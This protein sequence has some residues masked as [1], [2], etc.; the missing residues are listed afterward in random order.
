MAE[1]KRIASEETLVRVATALESMAN[2]QNVNLIP[3]TWNEVQNIVRNGLATKAFAI[4]DQ[5]EIEK[6]STA[7]AK[8]GEGSTGITAVTVDMQTIVSALSSAG[9]SIAGTFELIY[10]GINWTNEAG[11]TVDI[12]KW[13]VT[14]TGTAKENDTI[15]VTV[16]ATNL[17]FDVIGI[18]V[19]T[20]S[21][22]QFTHS[23]TL[24]L[25]DCY[26]ALQF[27]GTE[28]L[29]YCEEELPA[30]TYNFTLLAG[31]ETTYGGG[32]TYSFTL[33]KAVPAG[34]QIMFPWG[35]QKQAAD[36]KI[37]TYASRIST[38][39]LEEVSVTQEEAGTPLT[40]IGE[41]NHS[42]R[43]RYGSNNWEQ[44]AIRQWLNSDKT[45]G[46]VWAP[47]TKFDRP[48]TWATTTDGFLYGIDKSFLDVIGEVKKVTL[49]NTV[50]DNTEA[51][52]VELDEKFFLLANDELY[53]SKEGGV[54]QGTA[55]PYY[56]NYSD[57]SAPGNAADSNRIKYRNGT[58]SY[59]WM[60]SPIPWNAS[61]VRNVNPTG[62][63]D[64]SGAYNSLGIAP[65]CCIV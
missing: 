2:I 28:A 46:N 33:T 37:S 49:L 23:L 15:V 25:H 32:L 56:K 62:T 13:G 8:V 17:V 31:Y 48:P 20:P 59:W 36:I 6:A 57:L 19:D 43:I 44:S 26:T 61:T 16:S 5:I 47:Q 58:A 41:C 53:F 21:D 50:T 12:K 7:S 4:G 9:Y 35:Y 52:S 45:K 51:S 22:S 54:A 1:N 63:L 65:A 38:E 64:I 14:V 55:Y 24:Q 18:D 34:G 39:K 10:N 30:G 40:S 3:K 29:F 60:R 42:H 11:G 27:D